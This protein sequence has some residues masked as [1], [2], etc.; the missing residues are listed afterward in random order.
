MQLEKVLALGQLI[1]WVLLG[2]GH[3]CHVQLACG[4]SQEGGVNKPGGI[5]QVDFSDKW[6]G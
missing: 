2:L 1:E 3:G 4:Q 6:S 5:V